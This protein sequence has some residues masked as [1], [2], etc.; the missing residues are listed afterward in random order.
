MIPIDD[1][2]KYFVNCNALQ[3]VYFFLIFYN[4]SNHLDVIKSMVVHHLTTLGSEKCAEQF[5]LCVNI[6]ECT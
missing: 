6:V 1:L 3:N 5:G 2:W 4:Q